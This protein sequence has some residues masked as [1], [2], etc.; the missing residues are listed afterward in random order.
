MAGLA[1]CCFRLGRYEESARHYA[2]A[3]ALDPEDPGY[4]VR[5]RLAEARAHRV[6][7]PAFAAVP[8]ARV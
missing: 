8:V 6:S 5:R 4:A 2:R 7:A 3:E 1:L